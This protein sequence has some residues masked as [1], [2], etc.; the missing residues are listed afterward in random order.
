MTLDT[1]KEPNQEEDIRGPIR[2]EKPEIRHTYKSPVNQE[3]NQKSDIQESSQ[4]GRKPEI[5]HTRV[6]SIK[7]GRKPEIRHTRVQSIRKKDTKRT[8][9][10]PGEVSKA[11]IGPAGSM[12]SSS[13]RNRVGGWG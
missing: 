2:S 12:T 6:Q 7:S 9:I 1:R 11:S 13:F 10:G 5:R 3:E 4:S 8:R